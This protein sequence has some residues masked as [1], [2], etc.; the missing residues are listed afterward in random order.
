MNKRQF[1]REARRV[2]THRGGLR[3]LRAWLGQSDSGSGTVMGLMLIAIVA[4]ALVLVTTAG[5]IIICKSRASTAA[6]AAALA[7]ASALDE[8]SSDPCAQATKVA[9]ANKGS[10]TACRLKEQDVE[11]DVQVP[12]QVPFVSF[13]TAGARAGPRE[14]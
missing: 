11:V 10:L 12:T 7:G 1:A 6:D 3:H 4:L 8:G 14:C 5:N 9:S 2:R 13:V